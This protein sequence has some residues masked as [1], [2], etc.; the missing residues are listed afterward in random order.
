M[1]RMIDAG[2]Q[3]R[4]AEMVEHQRR[5]QTAQHVGQF[6][7][8]FAFHIELQVPAEVGNTFGQRL[9]HLGLHNAALR[10]ADAEKDAAHRSEEHTSELQSH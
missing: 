7:H 5:R 10:I 6:N 3:R 4:I 8:L 9:D 2:R 1:R